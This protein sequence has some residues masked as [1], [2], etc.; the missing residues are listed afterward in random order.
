MHFPRKLVERRASVSRGTVS[1][2]LRHS[3]V[4]NSGTY[5]RRSLPGRPVST[6]PNGPRGVCEFIAVPGSIAR[7]PPGVNLVDI[8]SVFAA[9]R[10]SAATNAVRYNPW[11]HRAYLSRTRRLRFPVPASRKVLSFLARRC[12]RTRLIKSSPLPRTRRGESY[13]VVAF[14]SR[15]TVIMPTRGT[16]VRDK[17]NCQLS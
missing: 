17:Q 15:G 5:S 16:S 13:R 10:E 9:L 11:G 6:I 1:I 14:K 7:P 8:C 12:R 4:N 3:G 2:D